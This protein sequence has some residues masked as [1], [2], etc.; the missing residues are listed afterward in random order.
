MPDE[1]YCHTHGIA[2]C[3]ICLPET[4]SPTHRT[5]MLSHGFGFYTCPAHIEDT[6]SWAHSLATT[7]DMPLPSVEDAPHDA[8]CARC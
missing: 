4:A 3:T 5:V 1:R 6:L 7:H 8:G 2:R